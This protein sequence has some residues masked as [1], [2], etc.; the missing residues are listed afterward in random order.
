MHG[1]LT[2]RVADAI[3]QL[4]GEALPPEV[5][6]HAE[7]MMLNV[8]ATSIAASGEEP[9]EIM[10]R[11]ATAYGGDARVAVPGR[12][13]RFD[14]LN[15]AAVTGLAAHLDDFDDTHLATV[16][17]P[18]PPALAAVLPAAQDLGVAGELALTAF[19]LACEIELRAGIAMSPW[20]YDAGW[21]ITATCG[22][23]GGAV[24]GAVLAQLSPSQIAAALGIAASQTLGL[25]A[26]HA[27]MAKA[28]AP[29]KAAANGL[30][31][32]RLAE[33]GFSAADD[34]LAG[35]RGFFEVLSPQADP[36]GM[37]DGLGARWHLLD[38]TFKPYPGGVVTHPFVDAAV[39]L[40]EQLAPGAEPVA[41]IARC[42]PL[43]VELTSTV[44]PASG[45]AARLS[46]PHAIAA[47]LVT[48]G[49]GLREY[50]RRT[51]NNPRIAE[52]RARVKLEV[53]D[54][55]RADEAILELE[56]ADGS[57]LRE[58]V[59]HARGS[60]EQPLTEEQL[61]A[62]ATGLIDPV[63]P[64]QT[65]QIVAAVRGLQD[66]ED[67]STLVGAMVPETVRA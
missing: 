37:H 65:Q 15:A 10:A 54:S 66:A 64:G 27:T 36:E 9:V 35:T 31:S 63:L 51:L 46:T 21:H 22:V 12:A 48:G 58:H 47:A 44:H 34:A 1:L 17:H 6:A 41:I 3:A 29:G 50:R 59:E 2:P 42:H 7:M 49:L 4:A 40:R 52:Q 61:I 33:R 30:L 14:V 56:F 60:L 28:W 62:K 38:T 43:V 20:H 26:A 55:V 16:I 39:A 32:S 57:R 11:F 53:T 18:G 8:L 24:A 45:M 23:L 19:A 13:D 67:A 25:R 5:R